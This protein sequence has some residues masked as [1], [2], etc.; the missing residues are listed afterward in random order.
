LEPNVTALQNLITQVIAMSRKDSNSAEISVAILFVRYFLCV[1][2]VISLVSAGTIVWYETCSS[3]AYANIMF[4]CDVHYV[5]VEMPLTTNFSCDTLQS[6]LIGLLIV[7]GE[8]NMKEKKMN[9]G[10]LKTRQEIKS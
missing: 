4:S 8:K 1:P 6:L 10:N 5:F 2:M 7:E 3:D 9:L